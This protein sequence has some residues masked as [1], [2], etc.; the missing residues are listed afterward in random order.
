MK[1]LHSDNGGEYVALEGIL[2]E[3]GI[4]FSRSAPYTPQDNA[5][6]ERANRT[7]MESA[8][9]MLEHAG[10]PRSFWAEVVTHATDIR[11]RFFRH[12]RDDVTSYQ[13]FID[14][15]TRVDHIRVFGSHAWVH[16]PKEKRHELDSKAEEGVLFGCLGN[17][18]YN[19]W[20]R[21]RCVAI[22]SKDVKV[23]ES[24][25]P[26]RDW[27]HGEYS[28]ESGAEAPISIP[29]ATGDI[30]H[31]NVDLGRHFLS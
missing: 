26:G 30:G 19:V 21:D 11:N 1:P 12:G 10:L 13:L 14:R 27:Y 23:D 3:H 5:I 24:S 17:N 28:L 18:C 15:R 16:V 2:T 22:F 8:R 4:E 9:A 6:A 29:T 25:F 31:S 20:L 7:V